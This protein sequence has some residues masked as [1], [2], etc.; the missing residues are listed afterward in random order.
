MEDSIRTTKVMNYFVSRKWLFF[1]SFSLGSSFYHIFIF[2]FTIFIEQVA[3]LPYN[4]CNRGNAQNKFQQ[5]VAVGYL[6]FP[7]KFYS[8]FYNIAN[9]PAF[10]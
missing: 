7:N 9:S 6:T 1:F 10:K 8:V 4:Y 2:R 5:A 3:Y